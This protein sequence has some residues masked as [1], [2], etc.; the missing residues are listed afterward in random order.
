MT[1]HSC[2]VTLSASSRPSRM[3][4]FAPAGRR[5]RGAAAFP[6]AH[7]ELATHAVAGGAVVDAHAVLRGECVR[8]SPIPQPQAVPSPR[9]RPQD[10][11]P[12]ASPKGGG[13]D[14]RAPTWG[15]Q[16]R[17]RAG[18]LGTRAQERREAG[19]TLG[20][21]ATAEPAEPMAARAWARA[22]CHP[23]T[24]PTTQQLPGPGPPADLQVGDV[25]IDVHGGRHT[26]LRHVLVVA[27]ARLAVHTIDAGDGD[28]LVAPSN[29]PAAGGARQLW[30]SPAPS[31]ASAAR[32]GWSQPLLAPHLLTVFSTGV[33]LSGAASRS[34]WLTCSF[35]A[36]ATT[37]WSG[38]LYL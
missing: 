21:V 5:S 27:G 11:G 34:A 9:D 2:F 20:G 33:G 30:A 15:L 25:P 6:L 31:R 1:A 19:P 14:T 26:V 22:S 28:P 36:M 12:A 35:L 32:P 13:E 37:S 10:P 18:G 38:G 7:A 4:P 24:P 3:R 29:V 17:G 16:E 23:A 8:R